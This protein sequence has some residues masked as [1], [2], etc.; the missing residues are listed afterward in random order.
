MAASELC[1]HLLTLWLKV[2]GLCS[3]LKIKI[4]AME[5]GV[6]TLLAGGWESIYPERKHGENGTHHSTLRNVL[7]IR[8]SWFNSFG[9]W[10]LNVYLFPDNFPRLCCLH[11]SYLMQTSPYWLGEIVSNISSMNMKTQI[12]CLIILD[13]KQSLLQGSV[14][15]THSFLNTGCGRCDG[16]CSEMAQTLCMTTLSTW[17]WGWIPKKKEGFY[18]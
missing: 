10:H 3:E 5:C 8:C 4:Q 7:R 1:P 18:Y 13:G 9:M 17:S 12:V 11:P 16:F 14:K 6:L 15:L 2:D